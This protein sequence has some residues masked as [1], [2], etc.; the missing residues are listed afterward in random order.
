MEGDTSSDI[1]SIHNTASYVSF[2]RSTKNA[3]IRNLN[4]TEGSLSGL[5]VGGIVGYLN[6]GY[7]LNCT[8]VN[9]LTGVHYTA[10][11]VCYVYDEGAILGCVNLGQIVS[12]QNYA[13]G[14]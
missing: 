6:N 5:N 7:V 11:I 1:V 4:F 2:I 3:A 8:N 12:S 10:G 9:S 14:N 13:T